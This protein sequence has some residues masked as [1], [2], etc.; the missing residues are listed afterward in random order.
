MPLL[1]LNIKWSYHILIGFLAGILFIILNTLS[2]SIAIGF[3]LLPGLSAQEIF[4]TVL[5]PEITRFLII[6][7]LAPI[8]KNYYSG[9]YL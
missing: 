6:V 8:A 5:S 3:P 9:L 2:P 1:G 4:G 7:I